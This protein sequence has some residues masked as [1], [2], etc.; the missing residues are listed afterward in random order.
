[1]SAYLFR[2]VIVWDGIRD[3]PFDGE[4]LV[5]GNRIARGLPRG[6]ERSSPRVAAHVVDGGGR[7]MMPA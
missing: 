5:E 1:M 7:F 6:K 3:V 4:V 2:N